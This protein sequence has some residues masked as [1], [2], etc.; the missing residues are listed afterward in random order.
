M[1]YRISLSFFEYRGIISAFDLLLPWYLESFLASVFF[2]LFALCPIN[3]SLL[4]NLLQQQNY[5]ALRFALHWF[6]VKKKKSQEKNL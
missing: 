5:V 6:K 1:P 4:S 3:V 2:A